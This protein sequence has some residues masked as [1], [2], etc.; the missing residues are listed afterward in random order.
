MVAR[1]PL[2]LISGLLSELPSGD[3]ALAG[4]SSLEVTAGSGL[5]GGGFISS[6][7]TYN[8]RLAAQPS[9]L[10]F[11]NDALALD[12]VALARATVAEASGDN[13]AFVSS[14]AL[15]SGNQALSN[16]VAALASGNAALQIVSPLAGGG[17]KADFV[18]AT[19]I[20]AGVPVGFNDA[21]QIE[22]LRAPYFCLPEASGVLGSGGYWVQPTG[23]VNPYYPVRANRLSNNYLTVMYDE[24]H[25]DFIALYTPGYGVLQTFDAG[26]NGY[27]RARNNAFYLMG[28]FSA[29][30]PS[31]AY[32]HDDDCYLWFSQYGSSSYP[33][34]GIFRRD[35]DRLYSYPVSTVVESV[36]GN[37]CNVNYL[38]SGV[39]LTTYTNGTNG[40]CRAVFARGNTQINSN[41][42]SSLFT[43]AVANYISSV[44][45]RQQNRT[46]VF[47][48]GTSSYLNVVTVDVDLNTLDITVGPQQ[49]LTT[50]AFIYTDA[51]YME[52][53]DAYAV[54]GRYGSRGQCFKVKEVT[55]NSFSIV[56]S[57]QITGSNGAFTVLDYDP[58]NRVFGYCNSENSR[59]VAGYFQPSGVN[60]TPATSGR[61]LNDTTNTYTD[62]AFHKATGQ[63][64]IFYTMNSS[65]QVS[66]LPSFQSDFNSLP[67]CNNYSNFVGIT[68][69]TV[70][71]GE[72]CT[73]LL[74]GETY[75]YPSGSFIPGRPL[76]LDTT[77]SGLRSEPY[78]AVSWSGQIPWSSVALA[79][80]AS[81]F[82]LLNQL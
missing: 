63:F 48:A 19:S 55:P 47:F 38:A 67:T 2:V 57:G 30:F 20:P 14:S 60:F 82:V 1:R 10:I 13:A 8:I 3:L 70:N 34:A 42:T 5:E 53:E 39:F 51:V 25:E 56:G 43:S 24:K 11:A 69:D 59:P 31:L 9:G 58:L 66:V 71:S 78:P 73:V 36:V 76:Y 7:P 44:K 35:E 46:V 29:P 65:L 15:A 41:A 61:L 62:C 52:D 64:Y 26:P 50:S 16:S 75:T 21:G 40:R 68:N 77:T 28:N 6:A 22:P 23:V 49:Q 80:S 18:A 74:P 45:H 12:G 79:T 32:N 37:Y 17:S 27:I 4:T 72:L 81:G 33:F 54:F